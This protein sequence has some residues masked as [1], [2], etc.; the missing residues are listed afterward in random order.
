MPTILLFLG[1]VVLLLVLVR[2]L[3]GAA[4][5]TRAYYKL[6]RW[7]RTKWPFFRGRGLPKRLRPILKPLTPVWVQVE[8]GIKML[9]VADDLVSRIIL[10]TGVW[11]EASWHCIRRN[12]GPGAIF[13]DVGAHMG[14][15]SLKAASVVGP[16]GR[17]I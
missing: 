11:E 15:F 4:A 17:V 3:T 14:Y 2:A 5:Q 8:P 10:E 6:V 16:T 7:W 13:V 9:L 12:L 1:I